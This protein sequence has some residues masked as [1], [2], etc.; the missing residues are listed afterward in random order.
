MEVFVVAAWAVSTD[1]TT[2]AMAIKAPRLIAI[3]LLIICISLM[4]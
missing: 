4:K 1:A 2:G 3:Y